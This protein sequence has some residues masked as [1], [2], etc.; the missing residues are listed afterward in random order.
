MVF[1]GADFVID[2]YKQTPCIG[3]YGKKIEGNTQ[4]ALLSIRFVLLID[5]FWRVLSEIGIGALCQHEVCV[6]SPLNVFIV[7]GSVSL[8]VCLSVPCVALY[9]I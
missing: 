5:C 7:T 9:Q 1:Y 2:T 3:K 6:S 4:L 8:S